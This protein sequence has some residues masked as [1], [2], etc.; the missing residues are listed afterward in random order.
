M[1]RALRRC[2]NTSLDIIAFA[3]APCNPPFPASRRN[4]HAQTSLLPFQAMLSQV[5]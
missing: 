4:L 1:F 2:A 3:L 5:V